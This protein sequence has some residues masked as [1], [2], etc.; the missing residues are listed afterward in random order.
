MAPA[1]S[2]W[3]RRKERKKKKKGPHHSSSPKMAISQ[4]GR[5]YMLCV[6]HRASLVNMACFRPRRLNRN[7]IL[8][9]PPPL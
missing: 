5:I 2:I 9:L 4:T 3:R 7:I 1:H 8:I 6:W